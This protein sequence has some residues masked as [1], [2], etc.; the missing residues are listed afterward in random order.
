MYI[1]WRGWPGR[2]AGEGRAFSD[3]GAAV[4]L[5]VVVVC[6]EEG[7]EGEAQLGRQARI[8]TRRTRQSL[9]PLY[10]SER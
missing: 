7:D 3:A 2:V 9:P 4:K 10:E 6:E 8:R 1:A 5:V